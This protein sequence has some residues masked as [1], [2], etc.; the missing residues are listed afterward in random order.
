MTFVTVLGVTGGV[1]WNITVV[2]GAVGVDCIG[3]FC[4]G[5]IDGVLD[6][7]NVVDVISVVCV[8][9]CGLVTPGI[10]I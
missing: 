7:M 6:A 8:V 5:A 4:I 3:V 10:M 2:C 1:F 9:V